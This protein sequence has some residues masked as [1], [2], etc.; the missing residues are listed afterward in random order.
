M[1]YSDLIET[2]QHIWDEYCTLRQISDWAGFT[3]AQDNR[4][5]AS[6][7]WLVERR[8]EI[9]RL[10]QPKSEGGDGNGWGHQNRAARYEQLKDG[11][12]N[13][14][15]PKHEYTLPANG[16]TDSEKAYIEEREGY[17]MIGG[18]GASA[19]DDQKR[20]KTANSDWLV[21]RRKKVWHLG[22]EEGWDEAER[23]LR[24][25]NLC[26]AT[27][28]GSYW[29]IYEEEHNKYGQEKDTNE[30]SGSARADAVAYCRK[31]LGVNEDP[32]NS[33]R[34]KHIDDWCRR[35]YGGTGVPWCACFS[36]C[37]AW[38]AGCSGSSSA[39]VTNIVSL[40]KKGQ[41]I[42]RGWTT[43]P[44]QVLRGDMAVVSCTSCHIGM[45]VDSD[46][47]YHTIE[48]NTS[49]GS[50]GSQYDGGCVAERHR[51]R[52]EIIGWALVDYPS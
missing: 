49:P 43:D 46:D 4:R 42:Y 9:W 31:Y 18:D 28:H 37:M 13:T 8:K 12:L 21:E 19:T 6:R 38:D 10:A 45:V 52:G 16:C 7:D 1:S 48:G 27:H 2:E 36:T 40:A 23:E 30:S 22:E 32:P 51:G 44:G 3:D 50:E 26:I 15:A 39:A 14:G 17:L 25:E 47:A 34:G 35:V 20:R 24:Y 41:G 33:N 11:S 5:A 29:N